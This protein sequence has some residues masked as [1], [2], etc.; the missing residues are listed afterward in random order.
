MCFQNVLKGTE[1]PLVVCIYLLCFN[2]H[3]LHRVNVTSRN[4]KSITFKL[5]VSEL[6]FTLL[7]YTILV[8]F[9]LFLD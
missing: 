7:N 2:T 1:G 5:L 4:H 9:P 8:L 6:I 3:A